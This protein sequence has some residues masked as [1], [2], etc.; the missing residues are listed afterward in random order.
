VADHLPETVGSGIE[1]SEG[2]RSWSFVADGPPLLLVALIFA[3]LLSLWVAPGS[4][5]LLAVLL[6]AALLLTMGLEFRRWGGHLIAERSL[7][8]SHPIPLQQRLDEAR[9]RQVERDRWR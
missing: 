5:A 1:R 9:A 8:Q 2:A 4:P 6:G 3:C 7:G